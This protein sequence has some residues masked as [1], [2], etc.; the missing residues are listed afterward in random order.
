VNVFAQKTYTFDYYTVYEFKT[1][2]KDSISTKDITIANSKDSSY[3]IKISTYTNNTANIILYDLNM[4]DQYR[5]DS[6]ITINENT[7][8]SSLFSNPVPFIYD[9]K[10]YKEKAVDKYD[11][12]HQNDTIIVRRYKNRRKKK[13][14]SDYYLIM[15]S[16]EITKNQ[17]YTSNLIFAYKFDISKV[18]TDKIIKESFVIEYDDKEK[19]NK[20]NIRTLKDI[21]PID[22]TLNIPKNIKHN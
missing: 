19:N 15:E 16:N 7:D 13:I 8:F 2:E 22:F 1:D 20:K 4:K 5:F 11:A 10:K 14:V 6:G 21:Q 18:K 12:I 17:L 3:F 9:Y